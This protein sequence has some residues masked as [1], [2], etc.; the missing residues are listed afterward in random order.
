[1]SFTDLRLENASTKKVIPELLPENSSLTTFD[2]R[3]R[4]ED[5]F[6]LSEWLELG[7]DLL[8]L[9]EQL[10]RKRSVSNE[11]KL[12]C[13]RLTLLCRSLDDRWCCAAYIV[14]VFW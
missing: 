13:V 5:D 4:V 12:L 1:M 9:L 2:L 3:T 8:N 6:I 10:F 14:R 11:I 7:R